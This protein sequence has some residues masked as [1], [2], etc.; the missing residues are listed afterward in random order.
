MLS[1]VSVSIVLTLLFDI[2]MQEV[3]SI[4][5]EVSD[6]QPV[7]EA[8]RAKASV[9]EENHN[10]VGKSPQAAPDEEEEE[11][12]GWNWSR[13]SFNAAKSEQPRE[14]EENGGFDE[15]YRSSRLKRQDIRRQ[16][17]IRSEAYDEWSAVGSRRA[18]RSEEHYPTD[19]AR[20][21][22]G[23]YRRMSNSRLDD[24]SDY[25]YPRERYFSGR[26]GEY[27]RS[28]MRDLDAPVFRR[29]VSRERPITSKEQDVTAR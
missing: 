26:G 5:M 15:P 10:N 1:V 16:T 25:L 7:E 29:S 23:D 12:G 21:S 22:R 8:N 17:M 4:V 27:N 6:S 19:D 2:P 11:P 28:P 3:K 13:G 14:Y 24:D 20:S 9:P 18:S